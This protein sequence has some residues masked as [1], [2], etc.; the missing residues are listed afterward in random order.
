LVPWNIDQA[1]AVELTAALR[2]R[3]VNAIRASADSRFQDLESADRPFTARQT[4]LLKP[5]DRKMMVGVE[6]FPGKNPHIN[7]AAFAAGAAKPAWTSSV[8]V[9]ESALE[10]QKNIPPRNRKIVDFARKALGRPVREGDCTHLAEDALQAAGVGKRGV[11][12]WGRELG[13]REPWL[14]GDILQM[15]RVNVRLPSGTRLFN[16]HTAVIEDVNHEFIVVLHQNALPDG[17]AVQRET[18]PTAGIDNAK[19]CSEIRPRSMPFIC[20]H[21]DGDQTTYLAVVGPKTAWPGTRPAKREVD[22]PDGLRSTILVVEVENSGIQWM[23]PRDLLFDEMSFEINGAAGNAISSRHK[24]GGFWPW[25]GP[26]ST[27]NVLLADGPISRLAADTAPETIRVWITA[28]GGDKAP[29][30]P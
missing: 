16:H 29:L 28:S 14:P 17:K 10:L 25:S 13:P 21:Q 18:W 19:L 9:P 1:F 30:P 7:L 12:R 5:T 11:Y 26:T 2:R 23:E 24:V 15:Q 20:P 6:W 3:R 27:V 22:F 4:K 8:D